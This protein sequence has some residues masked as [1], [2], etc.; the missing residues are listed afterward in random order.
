[1]LTALLYGVLA[2]SGLLIGVTIGLVASP[3]RRL[4]AAVVA[5]GSGVLVS[6]LTFE[7]MEEAFTEGSPAF[8]VGG[9]LLGAVIYVIADVLLERMAARS[10]QR[11][12]RDPQDVVAGA[13]HIPQTTEQATVS[14]TALLV[15]AALDGIPENAAIGIGLVADG[16]GLAL[17]L[18]GAVFLG[19][20]PA[21]MSSAV[22]M[23]EEGRSRTYILTARGTVAITCTLAT[24]LGYTLLS[25]L[26][27]NLIGAM[28]ALAAG[29]ILAMLADT[30]M[31]EAFQNGGPFVALATAVGFACAFL[32]SHLAG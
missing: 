8:T 15:G 28:L 17:V 25:G 12:G 24:V 32:L 6:A 20:L 21:S 10:P 4:V 1:M 19:N 5:F 2:S 26:S 14:G 7:L 27:P 16:Q 13:E 22:G 11:E 9:F 23:R 3:P 31:P 18:L 30:M 29:G